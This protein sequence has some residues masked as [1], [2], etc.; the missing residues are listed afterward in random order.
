MGFIKMISFKEYLKLFDDDTDLK[1]I[2]REYNIN[3]LKK[4]GNK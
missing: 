2:I 4:K 1:H 3:I